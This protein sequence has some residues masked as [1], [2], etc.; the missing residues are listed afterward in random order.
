M[1]VDISIERSIDF[2]TYTDML[3]TTAFFIYIY[4]ISAQ[5]YA[6]LSTG[7]RP[8]QDLYNYCL[9]NKKKTNDFFLTIVTI[10]KCVRFHRSESPKSGKKKEKSKKKKKEKK[11]KKAEVTS[12]DSDS[13]EDSDDS[14]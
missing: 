13:S 10:A 7:R 9:T 6:H 3:C 8:L 1:Y 5:R 4:I 11:H 12:S 14:K 2:F